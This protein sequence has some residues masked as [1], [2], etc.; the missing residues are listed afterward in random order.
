MFIC[1]RKYRNCFRKANVPRV[2]IVAGICFRFAEYE[3]STITLIH[4]NGEV[5]KTLLGIIQH[6][7]TNLGINFSNKKVICQNSE[8][9]TRLPRTF[10]RD[11]TVI[12]VTLD[13][14]AL[15]FSRAYLK[16]R[17]PKGRKNYDVRRVGVRIPRKIVGPG[18][19]C[20]KNVK[21]VSISDIFR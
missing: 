4:S 10:W 17:P 11:L 14:R 7:T 8:D 1:Q 2:D 20:E 12:Y 6:C 19:G 16:K 21:N 13:S 5:K 18:T 9:G 15:L 3:F